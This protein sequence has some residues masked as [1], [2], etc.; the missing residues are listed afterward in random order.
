MFLKNVLK[1]K[2]RD[3]NI[4][5]RKNVFTSMNRSK[6]Q[7]RSVQSSSAAVN[8]AIGKHVFRTRRAPVDL[9]SLSQSNRDADA[10]DQSMRL[11]GRVTR[12]TCAVLVQFKFS[13]FCL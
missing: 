5:K 1:L 4:K 11:D 2:K 3:K 6:L 9:V 13:S 10:R 8:S 7:L 12:A